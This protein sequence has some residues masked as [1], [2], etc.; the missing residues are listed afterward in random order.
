MP[1]RRRR[2]KNAKTKIVLCGWG[3]TSLPSL[4]HTNLNLLLPVLLW[5]QA[6]S[7]DSPSCP[8]HSTSTLQHFCGHRHESSR[9]ITDLHTAL[10]VFPY[11]IHSA[12]NLDDCV[13]TWPN[14]SCVYTLWYFSHMTLR[15]TS[16]YYL[17]V[18]WIPHLPKMGHFDRLL[19]SHV[20]LA[21]GCHVRKTKGWREKKLKRGRGEAGKGKKNERH[22][23]HY[24]LGEKGWGRIEGC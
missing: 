15:F 7:V 22:S 14:Q 5:W 13:N 2:K 24:S 21:W 3:K 11:A 17:H 9:P 20:C 16:L 23:N 4:P 1:R 12:V 18:P 10:P 6:S 19:F 8:S